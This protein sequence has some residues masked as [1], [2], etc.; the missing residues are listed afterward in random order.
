MAQPEPQPEKKPEEEKPYLRVLGPDEAAQGETENLGDN[1]FAIAGFML[2]LVSLIAFGVILGPLAIVF[3][4]L[5]LS[6]INKGKY[7]GKALAIAAIIIGGISFLFSVI[8]LILIYAG[9]IP[10]AGAVE[11]G[12]IQR[13]GLL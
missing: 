2:S 6:E 7:T 3:G 1:R 11:S 4:S 8:Y 12:L 10:A 13:F 9:R 5:G